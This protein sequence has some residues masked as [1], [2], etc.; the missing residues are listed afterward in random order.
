MRQKTWTGRCRF[1]ILASILPP[2][3]IAVVPLGF[4][5]SHPIR[6]RDGVG[7]QTKPGPG[8]ENYRMKATK[9]E[10][11]LPKD[12]ALHELILWSLARC[13]RLSLRLGLGIKD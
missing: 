9:G 4:Y 5:C 1:P 11:M 8:L 10:A 13:L 7:R 3:E 12:W 2:P 6:V